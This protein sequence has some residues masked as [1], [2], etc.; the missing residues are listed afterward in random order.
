[1]RSAR[2]VADGHIRPHGGSIDSPLLETQAT[3]AL[4]SPPAGGPILASQPTESEGRTD[5]DARREPGGNRV[6][7]RRQRR[8]RPDAILALFADDATVVNEGTTR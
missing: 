1:M 5:D 7:L 8:A 4:D 2:E 3:G 6:L